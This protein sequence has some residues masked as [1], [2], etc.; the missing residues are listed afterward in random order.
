MLVWR[1]SISSLT[2]EYTWK[3][4]LHNGYNKCNCSFEKN[5]NNETYDVKSC[6][7]M[8]VGS[9]AKQSRIK[10]YISCIV[11]ITI[12]CVQKLILVIMYNGLSTIC[13]SFLL[14]MENIIL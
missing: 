12:N 3:F 8:H 13:V 5:I 1:W 11:H 2:I 4:L 9:N 14:N 7:V 6:F 10:H